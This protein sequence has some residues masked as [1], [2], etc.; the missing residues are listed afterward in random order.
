MRGERVSP[1]EHW[2]GEGPLALLRDGFTRKEAAMA[3]R[4]HRQQQQRGAQLPREKRSPGGAPDEAIADRSAQDHEQAG[5]TLPPGEYP[6][7]RIEDRDGDN[8]PSAPDAEVDWD[9]VVQPAKEPESQQRQGER[10]DD[11]PLPEGK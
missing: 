1:A 5:E 7:D 3:W 10:P 11:L 4:L 6:T 9:E 2:L 8:T